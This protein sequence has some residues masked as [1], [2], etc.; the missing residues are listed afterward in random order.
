MGGDRKV[1]AYRC[2]PDVL[3]NDEHVVVL[4]TLTAGRNDLDFESRS[5]LVGHL[6]AN[7][8]IYEGWS[9]AKTPTKRLRVGCSYLLTGLHDGGWFSRAGIETARAN[10]SG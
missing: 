8:K 5:V 7:R 9:S 6:G 4:Q 2:A 3:A 1:V 10:A